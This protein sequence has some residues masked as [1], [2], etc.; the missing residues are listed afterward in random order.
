METEKKEQEENNIDDMTTEELTKRMHFLKKQ[1]LTMEWDASRNQ[2]NQGRAT[3]LE[4]VKD[5]FAKIEI[6]LKAEPT[7]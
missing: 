3:Y 2:L 7:A 1:I 5:E 6:M 4:K